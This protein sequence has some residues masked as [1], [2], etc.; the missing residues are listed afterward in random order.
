M[1]I[2]VDGAALRAQLDHR[3]M[4]ER[5]G[6]AFHAAVVDGALPPCVSCGIGISRLLMLLL[7]R[8]HICEVKV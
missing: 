7:Q 3:G 4:S 8:G 6:L 5:L 1:G 2:R